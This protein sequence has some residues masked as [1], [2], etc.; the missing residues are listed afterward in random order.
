MIALTLIANATRAA[1]IA[2]VVALTSP[3]SASSSRD[4]LN[5]IQ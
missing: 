3:R 1:A 2:I 5:R 4:A